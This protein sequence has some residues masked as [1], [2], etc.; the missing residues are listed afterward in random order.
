MD[1]TQRA[2]RLRFATGPAVATRQL[3]G[4]RMKP[5]R[6][7]LLAAGLIAPPAS[8]SP[9][10]SLTRRTLPAG[11]AATRPRMEQVPREDGTAHGPAPGRAEAEAGHHPRPGRRLERLDRRDASRRR[12]SV[13]TA[14]SSSSSPR[15]SAST[16]CARCGP[17][18]TPRWTAHGRHQ[19]LL[20]RRSTP[21]R[22]RCSTPKAC[23]SSGRTPR[24][25]TAATP[26]LIARRNEKARPAPGFF[27]VRPL[28][29][30]TR[31]RS[32]GCRTV[33]ALYGMS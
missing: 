25:T 27:H 33:T 23:A 8:A 19:D 28:V 4:P 24:I 29:L 31:T 6:R 15:P 26:R 10:P 3:K 9:P 7:H 13:R 17:S 1:E 14:P 22:R 5:H 32:T 2:P 18:A 20:R 11:R 21:S 12:T 30:S 16:A